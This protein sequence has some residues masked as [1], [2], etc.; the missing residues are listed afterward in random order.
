[1]RCRNAGDEMTSATSGLSPC[2][3]RGI[4]NTTKKINLTSSLKLTPK[5]DIS[6]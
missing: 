1:M 6:I 5:H 3:K 4:L 2:N